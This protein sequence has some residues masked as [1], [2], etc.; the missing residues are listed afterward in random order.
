[1]IKMGM[2]AAYDFKRLLATVGLLGVALAAAT[3]GLDRVGG[4][5][6]APTGK[7]NPWAGG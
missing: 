2:A 5:A 4:G 1:M 6:P 7:K 3:H